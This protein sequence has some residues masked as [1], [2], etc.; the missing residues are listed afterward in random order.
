MILQLP[1]TPILLGLGV[2]SLGQ[3]AFPLRIMKQ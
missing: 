1:L 2:T 3:S